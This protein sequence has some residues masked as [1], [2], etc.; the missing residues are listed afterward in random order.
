[1]YK[2]ANV[3]ESRNEKELFKALTALDENIYKYYQNNDEEGVEGVV[4]L[5]DFSDI[6]SDDSMTVIN[7]IK[8]FAEF[9][10]ATR[11]KK[12]I[13]IVNKS[14]RNDDMSYAI[15]FAEKALSKFSLNGT[16]F[17]ETALKSI[18]MRNYAKIRFGYEEFFSEDSRQ[19]I[20]KVNLFIRNLG[21]LEGEIIYSLTY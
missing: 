16:V 21:E 6:A 19:M 1:M 11:L 9:Y 4:F 18:A 20:E 13:I 12:N 2:L 10:E 14:E 15:S 5:L 3:F 8:R 7:R 17:I